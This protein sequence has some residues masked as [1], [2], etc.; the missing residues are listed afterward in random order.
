MAQAALLADQIPRQLTF[1]HTVQVWLFWYRRGGATTAG[2]CLHAV[3]VLITEP[4]VGLRP[5]RIEPRALKR[6]ANAYPLLTKPRKQ[7]R[8]AVREHGHAKKQ[9]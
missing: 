1:K 8:A 5:G 3:L 9:R 2:A 7:A 4:R 6:R